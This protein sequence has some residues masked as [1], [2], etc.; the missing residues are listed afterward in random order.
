[1]FEKVLNIPLTQKLKILEL[2]NFKLSLKKVKTFVYFEYT[3]HDN[4]QQIIG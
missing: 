1:M 2:L 4:P 3:E